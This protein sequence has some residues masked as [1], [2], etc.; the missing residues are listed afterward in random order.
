M[1]RC[2]AVTLQLSGADLALLPEVQLLHP[3]PALD[4]HAPLLVRAVPCLPTPHRA[5][6][7]DCCTLLP[8]RSRLHP[9][10]AA[11]GTRVRTGQRVTDACEERV[12]QRI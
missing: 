5:L 8:P 12:S 10:E 7:H 3:P 9:P 2:H 6:D 11:R 1:Q 4:H